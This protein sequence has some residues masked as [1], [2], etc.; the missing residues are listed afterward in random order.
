MKQT[1]HT[2]IRLSM[3]VIDTIKENF[4]LKVSE[5]CMQ[6]KQLSKQRAKTV[7]E[8]VELLDCRLSFTFLHTSSVKEATNFMTDKHDQPEVA[9]VKTIHRSRYKCKMNNFMSTQSM[10]VSEV[11]K[12]ALSS[13]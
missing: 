6:K 9:Q 1:A 7:E 4:N 8:I 12:N 10:I 2:I 13:T 5:L 3:F 11:Y